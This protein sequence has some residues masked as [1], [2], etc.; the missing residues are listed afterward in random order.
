MYIFVHLCTY[1]CKAH[2]SIRNDHT[3][4]YAYCIN[5]VTYESDVR[6]AVSC[7]TASDQENIFFV[8]II[9]VEEL[10]LQLSRSEERRAVMQERHGSLLQQCRQ[11]ELTHSRLSSQIR[12]VEARIT[13]HR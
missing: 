12:D 5:F 9:Q 7:V 6:V 2:D 13:Q 11:Q 4:M 8:V 10:Q 1:D 3:H